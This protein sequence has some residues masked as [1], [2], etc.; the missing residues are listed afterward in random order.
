MKIIRPPIWNSRIE[1]DED[2]PFYPMDETMKMTLSHLLGF[3]ETNNYTDLLR[4]D[5]DGNLLVSGA[6]AA[7]ENFIPSVA[8]IGT[9]TGL[10]VSSRANRKQLLIRNNSSQD[11]YLSSEATVVLATAYKLDV[12]SVLTLDNYVG[13]LNGIAVSGSND[14]LVAEIF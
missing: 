2:K 8:S 12:D 9:T 14:L 13:A 10:V 3:N 5:G 7:G 1:F 4:I 6:G 11:V